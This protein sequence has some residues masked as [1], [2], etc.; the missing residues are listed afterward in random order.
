[1][2]SAVAG[3][4]AEDPAE[5]RRREAARRK[6][7]RY[8]QRRTLWRITGDPKCR[9]CGRNLMDPTT[10]ALVVQTAEGHSLVL[11]VE[12]CARIWLCPV[13]SRKIRQKRTEEIT[14]AVVD[15]IKR[16]G[17]AFLVSLTARH[18]FQDRLA[19]LMDA[20]QGTR[21]I[22]AKPCGG[23]GC[24]DAKPCGGKGCRP[25][26]PRRP[27]AY[28][29]L[30]TGGQWAGDPRKSYEAAV[31]GLRGRIGY[32]GMIRATE[33]TVG[34]VNLWHPHIHAIVLVGGAAATDLDGNRVLGDVFEVDPADLEAWENHWRTVW[35]RHLQKTNP[36]YRPSDSCGIPDCKCD[37]KGHGVDFKRLETA[38]DVQKAGE[39]IAK[40]QDGKSPAYELAAGDL[41][42]GRDG[43]MTPFEVLGR[44][45]DLMGGVDPETVP[46]HGTLEWCIGIWHEYEKAVSGRRAIE[47]T[48]GLRQLLGIEGG[49]TEED[50]LDALFEGEEASEFRAGVRVADDGWAAVARR[51]LDFEATQAAEGTDGDSAAI[52]ERMIGVVTDTG[53]SE[54]VAAAW[55][56][57]LSP[58]EV[59]EAYATILENQAR[60]RDEAAARRRRERD[61]ETLPHRLRLALLLLALDHKTAR[62]NWTWIWTRPAS[63]TPTR[64]P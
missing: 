13:C 42:S 25:R 58:T 3:A 54:A 59:G 17:M 40:T 26:V 16:G 4:T 6:A 46:G 2:A 60:R 15:W 32:V 7:A 33:V 45:G 18:D 39:Y 9:G 5:K 10:G 47:W 1:M 22:K 41:K 56:T 51:G 34:D 11:G 31:I 49:D 57:D 48:R 29:R 63:K 20:I 30:L 36:K 61:R 28:Q 53:T 8:G 35:T 38:R 37:G 64:T 44:I 24:T 23:D 52:R 62:H 55:V 50:D 27:G 21:E 19:D 12:K 14:R 43:N